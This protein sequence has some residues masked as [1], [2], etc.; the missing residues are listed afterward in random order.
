[1]KLRYANE[2]DDYVSG[3]KKM[4]RREENDKEKKNGRF[5]TFK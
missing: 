3:S 2:H 1:M 4:R 5:N